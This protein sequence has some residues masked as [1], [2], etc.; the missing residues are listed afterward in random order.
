MTL[1]HEERSPAAHV[2][3]THVHGQQRPAPWIVADNLTKRFGG[4]P[5]VDS[6][7]F[8]VPRGVVTAPASGGCVTS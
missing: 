5:A 1:H 4:H 6:L 8:E 2:V 3:T 7:T